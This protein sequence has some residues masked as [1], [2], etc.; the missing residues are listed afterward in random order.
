MLAELELVVVALGYTRVIPDTNGVLTEAITM[1]R[2]A[3]YRDIDRHNGNPYAYRF[4]TDLGTGESL[5]V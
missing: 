5:R 1:Y 2:S 3:D 4:A